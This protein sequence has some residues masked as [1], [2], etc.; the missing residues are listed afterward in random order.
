MNHLSGPVPAVESI[1][2][3]YFLQLYKN[4]FNGSIPESH[5]QMSKMSILD[6]SINQLSGPIPDS[7][8]N[9]KNLTELYLKDNNITVYQNDLSGSIPDNFRPPFSLSVQKSAE[10]CRAFATNSQNSNYNG[11][12]NGGG[13]GNPSGGG[14]DSGRK[15]ASTSTLF[16]GMLA[17]LSSAL[18]LGILLTILL[19]LRKNRRKSGAGMPTHA[20][21]EIHK[22]EIPQPTEN[23]QSQEPL[24]VPVPSQSSQPAIGVNS[25]ISKEPDS[26]FL[27]SST[28]S[29]VTA[30]TI[31]T[32]KVV[33]TKKLRNEPSSSDM[34]KATY[35]E[36][37]LPSNASFADVASWTPDQVSDWLESMDVSPRVASILKG[38][39]VTGYQLL[40]VTDEKLVQLGIDHERSRQIILV[41]LERLRGGNSQNV[42][43]RST[44]LAP[45]DCS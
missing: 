40:L 18:I 29:G 27:I 14:D 3:L 5:C 16:I 28:P 10:E 17:G 7:I 42:I 11:D 20:K 41:G 25:S 1:P 24:Y 2:S 26:L 35:N 38:N 9:L 31:E 33:P 4:N 22:L 23:T 30:T 37:T 32:L 19:F 15:D 12:V 45:P 44:T 36:T 13:N 8:G 6:I 34:S 43:T 39:A 21:Q